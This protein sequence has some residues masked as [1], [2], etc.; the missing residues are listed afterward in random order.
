[1]A[2]GN[3][4]G[5]QLGIFQHLKG[6]SWNNQIL[7]NA[8]DGQGGPKN[9]LSY[10]VM[11]LP[12]PGTTSEGEPDNGYILKNFRYFEELVF[13]DENDTAIPALAPNRGGEIEQLANA[14]FYDQKVLFAEG[15]DKG[16]PVHVENGLWLNLI[17]GHQHKGPYDMHGEV[18][19]EAK[20]IEQPS[21]IAIA[22][23]MSIPHGNSILALGK[24]TKSSTIYPKIP[25]AP[26]PHPKAVDEKSPKL[27]TDR[28]QRKLASDGNF[29]NP[30]P[31]YTLNSNSTIQEALRL[32]NPTHS[33]EWE[34]STAAQV[35]K[36]D[37]GSE[38]K[39]EGAVN[40]I[41]FEKLRSDVTEYTAKYWLLS[42]DP[43]GTTTPSYNYLLYT[44]N[45]VMEMQVN[46]HGYY[47]PHTTAN[48]LTRS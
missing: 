20:V 39:V 35:V 27:D 15:P 31:D 3:K 45:I 13:H 19:S 22:K 12:Q 16:T 37:N 6:S 43:V 38:I 18:N 26:D 24:Y 2:E 17:T 28:Y 30:N 46:G 44:Q 5:V 40:N 21:E 41:P 25:N 34:V 48:A 9:P 10:N 14:L 23:Q 4:K 29:Q 8:D 1:M 33:I 11:P 42:T 7:P 32:I 47:F 36:Y